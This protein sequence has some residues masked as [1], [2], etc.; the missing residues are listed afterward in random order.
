MTADLIALYTEI[1][2]TTLPDDVCWIVV[3]PSAGTLSVEEAVTRLGVR[4]EE[5]RRMPTLDAAEL[6]LY[7]ETALS[8]DQA[9]D[10]VA[11]LQIG[12]YAGLLPELMEPLSAGA[13]VWAVSWDVN[14][15]FTMLL[16]ADGKVIGG[17]SPY[18]PREGWAAGLG[19]MAPYAELFLAYDIDDDDQHARYRHAV[20]LAVIESESGVRLDRHWIHQEHPTLLGI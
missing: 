14:A 9:A 7:G 8:I 6:A 16:W 13:R 2:E 15:D 5:L 4:P 10:C 3:Q 19:A 18:E 11:I 17:W 20:C 12:G 1:A